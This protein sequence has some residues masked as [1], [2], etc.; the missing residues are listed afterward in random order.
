VKSVKIEARGQS[1]NLKS[2]AI[3]GA[4]TSGASAVA[5]VDFSSGA[6]RTLAVETLAEDGATR[7]AYQVTLK[8]LPADSNAKL[9]ALEIV[10]AP[11]FPAFSPTR[12]AYQTEVPFLTKQIVVKAKTQSKYATVTLQTLAVVGRI[13]SG[14][15]ALPYKGD[16]VDRAG[17]T[18]D[19]SNGAMLPVIVA[20]TAEDGGV[21]EYLV[22]VARAEPDHNNNLAEL[23]VAGARMSP[24]FSARVQ[25]YVVEV[26]FASTSFT[27]TAKAQ[28]PVATLELRGAAT[29]SGTSASGTA[30][31]LKQKGRLDDRA[32]VTVEFATGERLVVAV[33]VT[34]QD[35]KTALYTLDVRRGEP[36]RNNNLAELAVDDSRMSPVFSPRTLTYLVEVPF[37]S[38]AFV[39][40]AKTQS[41]VATMEL[42]PG[43]VPANTP[44]PELKQKGRLDDKAGVTVEFPTAQGI[45]LAVAVTAQDGRTVQYVLDV[46]RAPP[47]ANADLGNLAASAG[48]L[49]P[50]FSPRIISYTVSL[51]AN[52]AST[53]LTATTA[54]AVATV[55]VEG[56]TTKPA[57]TLEYQVNVANGATETVNLIVTAEDQTQKLYR[58][59]V[60]REAAVPGAKDAN[61]RLAGLQLAGAA[62]KPAFNPDTLEYA[63]TLAAATAS[64]TL[65]AEAE[66][67]V[68]TIAVDGQPLAKSGRVIALDPGAARTVTVAVTAE[69][70]TVAQTTLKLTREA[71]TTPPPST[72]PDKVSV[73]MKN[74]AVAA[75]ELSAL[76][77][78][79]GS[80]GEEATVTVRYYRTNT[81]IVQGTAPV[82]MKLQGVTPVLT[83]SWTS[84]GVKLERG[85]LVEVEVA[86]PD[87][88]K[89][90]LHYTEAQMADATVLVEVPFLLYSANPRFSW[91]ALGRAVQVTGYVSWSPAGPQR[92]ERQA[93]TGD[94][95]LNAKGEYG[96]QIVFTDSAG[97]VL[98]SDTVWTKP[99]LPRS[100]VFPFTKPLSLPEG[101]TLKYTL[102]AKDKN[103]RGWTATGTVQVWTTKPAYPSGFEPVVLRIGDDLVPPK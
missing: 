93:D 75:R 53:K 73:T 83:M 42:V 29:G 3:D 98:A 68:A 1:Q 58:V 81:V 22:E 5:T 60:S 82:S 10:D 71:G 70:G 65:T 85:R 89:N 76:S 100:H 37:S 52:V 17:A 96:V 66:S 55:A 28:S 64:V 25:A 23:A 91:P 40:R 13:T 86:I 24:A 39:V 54:S 7:D 31:D 4:P 90:F 72:G 92:S 74:L 87:G 77:S 44:Q 94:F 32:G 48:V 88:G 102:T 14:R 43:P 12:A 11:L 49:S 57:G 103:G 80:V 50:F 19:F 97:K 34:A 8:R 78:A 62:L 26:P 27:V 69:N 79:K 15:T 84:P 45:V 95:E 33:A 51:P 41:T 9:D 16:P 99:G 35:G 30:A 56:V 61:T 21:Q 20:V 46:R 63:A 38:K 2:I 6:S 67:P 18:V 47:D 101:A 59:R 36:D